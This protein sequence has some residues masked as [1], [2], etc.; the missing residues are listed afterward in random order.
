[1][2]GKIQNTT[3]E[4]PVVSNSNSTSI[5]QH[6]YPFATKTVC[7]STKIENITT[8]SSE[9]PSS[10]SCDVC[11]KSYTYRYQLI[12]HKCVENNLYLSFNK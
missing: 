9:Q 6:S 1:M 3:S 12:V 4:V 7:A 2:F 5:Q 11:G 10:N 8:E